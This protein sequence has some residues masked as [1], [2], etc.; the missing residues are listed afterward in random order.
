MDPWNYVC[1]YAC[2]V[3]SVS[4]LSVFVLTIFYGS[5]MNKEQLNTILLLG[6]SRDDNVFQSIFPNLLKI[7]VP[8]HINLCQSLQM[9][10]GTRLVKC[11]LIAH[12]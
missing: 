1:M 3:C 5:G 9:D 10:R 8:N 2:D 6:K 7:N 12:Y 4:K 11:W